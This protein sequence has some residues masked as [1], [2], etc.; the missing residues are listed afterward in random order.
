MWVFYHDVVSTTSSAFSM[1]GALASWV[2]FTGIVVMVP[3]YLE[4]R[5]P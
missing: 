1:G 4:R 2:V 5:K 3:T